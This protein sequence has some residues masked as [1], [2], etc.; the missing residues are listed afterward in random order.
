VAQLHQAAAVVEGPACGDARGAVRGALVN[1]TQALVNLTQAL[2]NRTQALVNR[3]QALVNRTQALVKRTQVVGGMVLYGVLMPLVATRAVHGA[4]AGLR[5]FLLLSFVLGPFLPGSNIFFY[6]GKSVSGA[7][8]RQLAVPH[9]WGTRLGVWCKW[10]SLSTAGG[11][12]PL[13]YPAG[14]VV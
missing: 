14:R 8:S 13:G 5:L 2:V 9:R 12:P 4:A 7:A 1:R 3:T 6:V 11:T 10:S